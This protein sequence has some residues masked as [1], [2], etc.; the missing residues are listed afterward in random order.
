MA[1]CL[2]NGQERR[3][4]ATPRLPAAPWPRRRRTATV[5]AGGLGCC[6]PFGQAAGYRRPAL[7]APELG[8]VTTRMGSGMRA[9]V[10]EVSALLIRGGVWRR[11]LALRPVLAEA[12]A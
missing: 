7:G 11:R 5:A 12:A 2:T 1:D 3:P 6:P 8:A 4:R 9:P 10:A